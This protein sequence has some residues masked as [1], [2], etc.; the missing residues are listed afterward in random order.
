VPGE[1]PSLVREQTADFACDLSPSDDPSNPWRERRVVSD[2]GFPLVRRPEFDADRNV[3]DTRSQ[4][5]ATEHRDLRADGPGSDGFLAFREDQNERPRRRRQQALESAV[6]GRRETGDALEG[7][8]PPCR[9]SLHEPRVC[10]PD[11]ALVFRWGFVPTKVVAEA[12]AWTRRDAHGVSISDR[13]TPKAD[14]LLSHLLVERATSTVRSTT[15]IRPAHVLSAKDRIASPG[16]LN[17]RMCSPDEHTSH[18]DGAR[19]GTAH[20]ASRADRIQG[21]PARHSHPLT[22]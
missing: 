17:G 15:S 7:C 18:P 20:R 9:S 6:L 1:L 2:E 11:S 19:P 8:K 12:G 16:R 10:A 14:A 22:W 4:F 21:A 13:L 3:L 5:A